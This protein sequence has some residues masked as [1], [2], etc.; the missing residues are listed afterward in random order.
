MSRTSPVVLSYSTSLME[1]LLAAP[2]MTPGKVVSQGVTA[3]ASKMDTTGSPEKI[4][5]VISFRMVE[6][7]YVW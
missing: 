7:V 4:K 6:G 1:G 3:G 2:P 5:K